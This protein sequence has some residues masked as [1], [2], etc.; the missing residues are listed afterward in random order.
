MIIVTPKKEEKFQFVSFF[1]AKKII[2]EICFP[3]LFPS[4]SQRSTVHG[5]APA[6]LP[7][8]NMDP[9]VPAARATSC[10]SGASMGSSNISM[11]AWNVQKG[12]DSVWLV[13]H[14]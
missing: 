2:N 8:A 9:P 4:F 13:N 5:R 1:G 14:Q 12:R 11:E 6:T 10:H 3:S 7:T